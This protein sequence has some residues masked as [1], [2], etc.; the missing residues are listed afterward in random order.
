[1][2]H[3]QQGMALIEALV[4]SAVLGIGLLGAT[5]LTLKALQTAT[6]TRQRGVA[7]LLAQEAMDCA[8]SGTTCPSQDSTEVQGVRYTRQTRITPRG[9]AVQDVQVTV[10]WASPQ[11]FAGSAEPASLVWHSSA[12]PMPGWVGR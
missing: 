1:M 4:A 10:Q 3:P 9:N 2:K 12:S 5:Q 11:A 8:L 6:D 7:Q